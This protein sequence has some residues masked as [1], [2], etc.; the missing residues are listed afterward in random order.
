[1]NIRQDLNSLILKC[2]GDINDGA[3]ANEVDLSED[4][5]FSSLHIVQLIMEIEQH[6]RISIDGDDIMNTDITKL[7]QLMGLIESKI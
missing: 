5:G 1:M 7:S 4:L 2:G 6:F 3:L